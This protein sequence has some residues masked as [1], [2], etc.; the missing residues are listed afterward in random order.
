MVSTVFLHATPCDTLHTGPCI[1]SS[2]KPE[3][4]SLV[5]LFVAH[6]FR[7][8]MA[9]TVPSRLSVSPTAL[10]I[11][12]HIIPHI[13]LFHTLPRAGLNADPNAALNAN[14]YAALN[15][16]SHAA[17]TIWTALQLYPESLELKAI[18]TTIKESGRGPDNE[19]L[20]QQEC[21]GS[22]RRRVWSRLGRER[23]FLLLLLTHTDPH[24]PHLHPYEANEVVQ[25][26]RDGVLSSLY[27]HTDTH[28]PSQ[29]PPA[30]SWTK[31]GRTEQHCPVF[32][33]TPASNWT[34]QMPWRVKERIIHHGWLG[35]E[36]C[37][38]MNAFKRSEREEGRKGEWEGTERGERDNE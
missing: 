16:N 15:A 37:I 22:Y 3:D 14:P 4:L 25:R 17:R 10:L 35:G 34:V 28:R 1:I 24:R 5:S 31:R 19:F 23:R 6:Y 33:H 36:N 38:I 30:L 27:S 7:S 18:P 11:S 20:G 21:N 29:T 12:H 9:S 26:G 8:L 32:I 13:I 2:G